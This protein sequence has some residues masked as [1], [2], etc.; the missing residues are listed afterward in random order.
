MQDLIRHAGTLALALVFV[1]SI[2]SQNI[3]PA[4]Q[5]AEAA[6]GYYWWVGAKSNDSSA[7]PN[8]GVRAIIDVVEQPGIPGYI[9]PWV[10][11]NL[12]NN[13]WIQVGYICNQGAAPYAF[14]QIWDLNTNTV[15]KQGYPSITTG[16]HTF[17]VY[18]KTG[19]TWA[20]SID[21]REITTY[22]AGTA[23]SSST[24]PVYSVVEM[25]NTVQSTFAFKQVSFPTAMEV[26][27][28]SDQA[29][30]RVQ[31]AKS[32]GNA[33]GVKGALQDETLNNNQI[34]VSSDFA[35]LV[36][37]SALW[38]DSGTGGVQPTLD[39]TPPIITVPL[40]SET[41]AEATS[42]SGAIVNFNVAASDDVGVTSGPTCNF[43]PGSLFGLGAT[44]V[45][46]SAS[47]AAGNVGTASFTVTVN[48][49]TPPAISVPSNMVLQ[50]TSPL[51]IA[52][53]YSVSASDLVDGA[54]PTSC[55]PASGS[56]FPLGS[57]LVLCKA[58]DAHGN[59]ATG[60]FQ[61]TVNA[62]STGTSGDTTPPSVS[63]VKPLQ[64]ATVKGIV[65]IS[66]TST[67]DSG[68]VS[69]MEI[70]IDNKLKT[71]FYSSTFDYSWNTKGIKDG[72]HTVTAKGYDGS[73]NTSSDSINLF[74]SNRSK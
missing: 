64:S 15:L 2:Y 70:Y 22:D 50:A 62:P 35:P 9:I 51:G 46:C 38:N 20:V 52:V 54:V 66:V 29:W 59:S 61:V 69:K 8:V 44:T 5:V 74:V 13:I 45:Q 71:T 65:P 26:L 68:A 21:D 42:A 12:S 32:Y 30:T 47:D 57:T 49:T 67:D 10:S 1:A 19:T 17:S 72:W 28:T 16:L 55:T 27:K 63:I 39:T 14:Y 34:V 41:T 40:S 24:Y 11:N 58:T 23:V 4:T 25:Y 6:T 48:D 43:S 56:T 31:T 73:G 36:S 33:W 53:T 60:T 37:G 3:L 7:L 18:L